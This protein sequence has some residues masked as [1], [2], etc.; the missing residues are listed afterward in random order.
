[1]QRTLIQT[2]S[3]TQNAI[4]LDKAFGIIEGVRPV[5]KHLDDI[6]AFFFQDF[7]QTVRQDICSTVQ[8]FFHSGIPGCLY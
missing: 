7:W 4:K 6:P 2:E 1:M 8:A 3:K 5:K